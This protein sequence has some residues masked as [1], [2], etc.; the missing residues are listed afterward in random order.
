MTPDYSSPFQ[1]R[2]FVSP[3]VSQ[4]LPSTPNDSNSPSLLPNQSP[5][6][7][8]L[9][10]DVSIDC[11]SELYEA[12]AIYAVVMALVFPVGVPAAFMSM[13]WPLRKRLDPK[14]ANEAEALV[15]RTNDE[16]LVHEVVAQ[17]FRKYR[18][19]YWWCK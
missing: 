18:P 12:Q 17:V 19:R 11:S 14:A 1:H 16:T 13:L 15:I 2:L 9:V 8:S 7:N 3:D 10:A 4:R 5:Q 6:P